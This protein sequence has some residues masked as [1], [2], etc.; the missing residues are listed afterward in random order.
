MGVM[1]GLGA[2]LRMVNLLISRRVIVKIAARRLA[3]LWSILYSPIMF[4]NIINAGMNLFVCLRDIIAREKPRAKGSNNHNYPFNQQPEKKFSHFKMAV[5]RV[6]RFPGWICN[7]FGVTEI[8]F[9]HGSILNQ[10]GEDPFRRHKIIII[11]K[12]LVIY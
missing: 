1:S 4:T 9:L 10:V 7:K 12:Y 8:H 11:Y 3:P 2:R 6:G 5:L